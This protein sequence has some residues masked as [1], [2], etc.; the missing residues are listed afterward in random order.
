M[1]YTENIDKT[2]SDI[3]ESIELNDSRLEQMKSSYNAIL[4]LLKKD[5]EFFAQFED[6]IEIFPQGSA[7]IGT[8]I[9]PKDDD[10]DLDLVIHIDLPFSYFKFS[11]IY[12]HLYRV[13]KSDAT[14]TDKVE[15]KNRCIRVNYK[16]DYHMDLLPALTIN[17]VK[18]Q[19]AVP[20]RVEKD[21]TLSNPEGFAS[22]FID[23]SKVIIMQE[24]FS[25]SL[26]LQEFTK[27]TQNPLKNTIKILKMFRDEYYVGNKADLKIPSIIL[28]SLAAF[29]YKNKPT[30]TET[31]NDF[32]LYCKNGLSDN[33]IFH[34]TNP[35]D[36]Q[37]CYSERWE[38]NTDIYNE[39]Q[40]F[41]E[42]LETKLLQ[43]AKEDN[44]SL[45]EQ[46][47]KSIVSTENFDSGYKYFSTR[48]V[49]EREKNK[50]FN[51]LREVTKPNSNLQRP[52]LK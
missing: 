24:D 34:F 44:L 17:K 52:Y 40:S 11:D 19:L 50:D 39:F 41:L 8:T 37:E 6:V 31:L 10:F 1:R 32:L 7:R 25:R 5:T 22:W 36:M 30:I 15:K 9:K 51:S 48:I 38:E 26:D 14:Y 29:S 28:T 2:L 47:I 35:A 3:A 43:L 21:W 12:N 4:D 45:R 33:S 42:E 16:G 49:S 18:K 27:S 46:I 20:D 13:L 23:K